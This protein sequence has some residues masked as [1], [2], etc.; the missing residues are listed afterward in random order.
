MACSNISTFDRRDD[1]RIGTGTLVASEVMENP[2]LKVVE[3]QTIS[4]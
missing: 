4:P 2:A 3:P 1:M